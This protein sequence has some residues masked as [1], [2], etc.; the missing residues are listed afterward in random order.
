MNRVLLLAALGVGAGGLIGCGPLS[1]P[2]P[3]RLADEDQKQVDDAWTRALT[4]VGK[5]DRQTW[6][7]V[8]VTTQAYETGVD[9]LTFRSEKKW[10]GGRVVMEV[11]YDRAKPAGDRFEVTVYDAAGKALRRERYSRD[12]VRQTYDD[13][14]LPGVPPKGSTPDPPGV[15]A[16][17]AAQ[18]ARLKR[19]EG[20]IPKPDQPKPP[21]TGK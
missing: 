7:D 4:P 9:S 20:I 13:L 11:H 12:E 3:E 16:R 21:A 15:A 17:R 6:L 19:I 18:E 10:A 2:I 14:N 5:P 8:F 1:R